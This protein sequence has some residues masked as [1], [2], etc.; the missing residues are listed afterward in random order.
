MGGRNGREWRD[1]GAR[2]VASDPST[3][4]NF[5]S[6]GGKGGDPVQRVLDAARQNAPAAFDSV[7]AILSGG[8]G[9]KAQRNAMA[10]LQA[11]KLVL[12]IAGVMASASDEH[13]TALLQALKSRVS[14][15]AYEEVLGVLAEM[16]GAGSSGPG[17]VEEPERTH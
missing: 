7:I 15:R 11:S 6:A 5:V 9:G 17:G 1:R 8:K 4:G 3:A 14:E 10:T 12:D 2:S 13:R 16:A